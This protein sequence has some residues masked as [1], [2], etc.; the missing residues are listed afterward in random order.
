MSEEK[1]AS[2]EVKNP[3]REKATQKRIPMGSASKRGL[4][5]EALKLKNF[6]DL[7]FRWCAD[8]GKGKVQDYLNAGWQ[9]VVDDNGVNIAKPGREKLLLMYTLKKHQEEDR[10]A[11]RQRIIETNR[12]V[13]KANTSKPGDYTPEG[14]D[15]PLV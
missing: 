11:N 15:A 1:K 8:Y 12:K 9:N 2:K 6:S 7:S 4:P 14:Y 10:L 13:Q 3:G 5:P